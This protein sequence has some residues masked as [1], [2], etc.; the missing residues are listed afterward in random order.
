[1]STNLKGDLAPQPSKTPY[2]LRVE[3]LHLAQEIVR[4]NYD[5]NL[6]LLHVQNDLASNGVAID[7]ENLVLKASNGAD[8][9][10]EIA[11]KLNKFVSNG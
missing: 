11:N 2:E 5:Q 3:I 1:M 7:T 4:T 6:G 9:V 10:L 8:E